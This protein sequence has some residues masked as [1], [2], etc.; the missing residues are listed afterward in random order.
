MAFD[1]GS[2]AAQ[3]KGL[4][5]ADAAQRVGDDEEQERRRRRA[6]RDPHTAPPVGHAGS[7]SRSSSE[8]PARRSLEVD[9][10]SLTIDSVLQAPR[11]IDPAHISNLLTL[12]VQPALDEEPRR[13][14][15]GG[16]GGK[17]TKARESASLSVALSRGATSEDVTR[18][19][20]ASGAQPVVIKI[21]STVSSRASAASLISYLGTREVKGADGKGEKTNIPVYDQEGRLVGNAEDRREL[22]AKW[23]AE[24]REEYAVDAIVT[25]SL[26]LTENVS[27]AALHNALNMAFGSKPFV[28]TRYDDSVAIYGVRDINARKLAAALK[29]RANGDGRAGAAERTF[30]KVM[31]DAGIE[32]VVRIEGAAISDKSGKYFL[33]KFIRQHTAFTTSG[34]QRIDAEG[35][36]RSMATTTWDTWRSQIRTVQPRNAFHV[37][38]S[39]RSGTDADAFNRT[40]RDFLAEQVA[41]HRWITAHHP[42]T[43]HVHVHAMIS[44]RDD[45]GKALRLTKPELYQWREAFAEKARQHGIPMVATLRSDLAATRPFSQAQ[46][47]AYA[48]GRSDPRYLKSATVIQRVELKREGRMD[49]AALSNSALALAPKWKATASVLQS[50][51]AAPGVI[52]AAQRFATLASSTLNAA[53]PKGFLIVQI[54]TTSAREIMQAGTIASALA[55]SPDA[56]SSDGRIARVLVPTGAGISNI[57]RELSKQD[58][59]FGPGGESRRVS[60]ELGQLLAAQGLQASVTIEAAGSAPDGKP[61]PWLKA[62]FNETAVPE[63]SGRE[64]VG[65]FAGLINSLKKQKEQKMA[66]SLEQFDERVARANKSMD[67]LETIVDSSSERQAVEEMRREIAALFSEQ[68]QQIELDQMRS[69]GS[70]SAGSSTAASAT[71][72]TRENHHPRLANVDPAI[73]AQQQAIAQGRA[74]RASRDQAVAAKGV[75]EDLRQQALKRAEQDRQHGSDRDGMDR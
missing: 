50:A 72:G 71:G 65:E 11:N 13:G 30:A 52:Q 38:F 1:W 31:K 36:A 2:L 67:R 63:K 4:V 42:E 34:G 47:G 41:G 58:Y 7:N 3:T 62:R 68:R 45:I 74:S 75:Q 25:I 17:W 57:E 73:T 26:T 27:D 33:E 14:G 64:A 40:V 8:K 43:G 28:Y 15:G 21:T 59:K 60:R 56:V 9:R 37:V 48:R 32:T 39:A 61:T 70:P 10:H 54:E 51:Q 24:F 55:V 66:L 6:Q 49:N 5:G 35:K 19:A 20:V 22:L 69:A 16:G 44:A 53:D 18:A 12:G 23:V 46:A 29:M